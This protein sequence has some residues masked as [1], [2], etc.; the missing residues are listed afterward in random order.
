MIVRYDTAPTLAQIGQDA[1]RA[2]LHYPRPQEQA[3]AQARV[4]VEVFHI[5]TYNK[6]NKLLVLCEL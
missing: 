3:R 4:H 6:N 2:V 1:R 5:Q